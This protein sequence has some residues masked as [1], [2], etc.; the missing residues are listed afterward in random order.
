M[1][2]DEPLAHVF[3]IIWILRGEDG[4]FMFTLKNAM[5]NNFHK[6]FSNDTT[7]KVTQKYILWK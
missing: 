5:N 3:T 1:L 6:I 2:G 7:R 4:Y